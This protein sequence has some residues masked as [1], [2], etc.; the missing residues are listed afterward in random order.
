MSECSTFTH[1]TSKLAHRYHNSGI[2]E[3]MEFASRQPAHYENSL[4]SKA[5]RI[6]HDLDADVLLH[7]SGLRE[8][9]RDCFRPR[10]DK[11]P[12]KRNQ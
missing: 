1:W 12:Q 8:G 4:F 3:L 6:A 10:P 11:L 7:T 9:N 5:K 2:R